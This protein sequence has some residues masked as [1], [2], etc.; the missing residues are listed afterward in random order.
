M[1][2]VSYED[3]L[4]NKSKDDLIQIINELH[5][6]LMFLEAEV[7]RLKV[8]SGKLMAINAICLSKL[9]D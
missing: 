5:Y 3:M 1:I 8:M 6:E 2:E 9:P 7:D 4:R